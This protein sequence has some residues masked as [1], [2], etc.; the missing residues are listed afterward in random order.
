[1][2]SYGSGDRTSGVIAFD[3]GADY[4]CLCFCVGYDYIDSCSRLYV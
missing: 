2:N 4:T 1:M 3:Y